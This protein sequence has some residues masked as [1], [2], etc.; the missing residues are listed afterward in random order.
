MFKQELLKYISED[1][2][3]LDNLKVEIDDTPLTG[4]LYKLLTPYLAYKNTIDEENRLISFFT[5]EGSKQQKLLPFYIGLSNYY[6]TFDEIK[7]VYEDEDLH[8]SE[9]EVQL[10]A[11]IE[12]IPE[13]FEY[14]KQTWKTK[15]LSVDI[16][17]NNR[18]HLYIESLERHPREIAPQ[19]QDILKQFR[20]NV[21]DFS[22]LESRVKKVTS[23]VN[24]FLKDNHEF[25]KFKEINKGSNSKIG[26]NE[27]L[28]LGRE[29]NTQPT[30]GVLLFTNKTKY[31]K[32]IE[33]TF[34]NGKPVT[35]T[36]PIAEII[37]NHAG[38]I[39]VNQN[40]ESS[41]HPMIFYCSSDYYAGWQEI[42]E[43]IKIDY[44]NT[45]VLDDFDTILKKE[46]KTDFLFF[47]EFANS[48]LEAQEQ[49]S[50]KDVYFLQNDTSFLDFDLLTKNGLH[51]YPWLLN[52]VERNYLHGFENPEKINH[53]V[54]SINDELGAMFWSRFRPIISHISSIVKATVWTA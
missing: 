22:A 21:D 52:H 19:I 7:T 29:V 17:K 40:S 35:K 9:I 44:L 31:K 53:L 12:A 23:S 3:E 2:K 18:I 30:S 14:L 8:T 28:K 50:L 48:I 10:E 34:F 46:Q 27:I 16:E 4:T 13:T 33:D 24:Q 6:K 45:I 54:L 41:E 38:E 25:L 39:S 51:A 20:N 49:N 36:F 47:K 43:C 1:Y 32:L 42:I 26:I 15:E 5:M 11:I 37:I